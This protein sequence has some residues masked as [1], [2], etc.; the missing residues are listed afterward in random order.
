MAAAG[1]RVLALSSN[2]INNAGEAYDMI[3]KCDFGWEWG[4]IIEESKE[5]IFRWQTALFERSP[6][7]DFPL[8]LLINSQEECVAI[9]R[10]GMSVDEI[11]LNTRNYIGINRMTRWHLAPPMSGTWFTNPVGEQYVRK[12]VGEAIVKKDR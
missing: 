8:S 9:Y 4:F 6:E 11:L 10:S 7:R 12:V 3:E 5:A 2:G 1:V